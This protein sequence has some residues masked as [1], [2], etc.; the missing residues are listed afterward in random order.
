MTVSVP[1][2]EWSPEM[3]DL[4]DPQQIEPKL[5]ED[6]PA[7]SSDGGGDRAQD[8]RPATTT[9]TVPDRST[10]PSPRALAGRIEAATGPSTPANENCPAPCNRPGH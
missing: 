6:A 1:R 5:S 4:L 2:A 7:A 9:S 10:Q 8:P 3:R